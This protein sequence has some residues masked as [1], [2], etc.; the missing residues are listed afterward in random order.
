MRFAPLVTTLFDVF[1]KLEPAGRLFPLHPGR[2][3]EGRVGRICGDV[4]GGEGGKEGGR[5][6]EEGWE[7][8][9]GMVG[10]RVG[11][12]ERVTNVL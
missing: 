1:L 2:K 7:R 10:G 9:G 3:G 8:E 6:R 11:G 5:G 4:W 12:R